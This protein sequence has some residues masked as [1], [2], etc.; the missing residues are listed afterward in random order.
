MLAACLKWARL[1]AHKIL[2]HAHRTGKASMAAARGQSLTFCI[3]FVN[4][5]CCFAKTCPASRAQKVCRV[6]RYCS[7]DLLLA[8]TAGHAHRSAK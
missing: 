7:Q 2:L 1:Q 5:G 6:P 8:G 3:A 4:A